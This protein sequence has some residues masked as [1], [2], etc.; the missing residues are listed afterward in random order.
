MET[1]KLKQMNLFIYIPTKEIYESLLIQLVGKQIPQFQI[2]IFRSIK[3]FKNRLIKPRYEFTIA[4]VFAPDRQDI[5]DVLSLEHFLRDIQI[6]LV[7]S[8][9]NHGTLS[10]AHFLR[11]RFI[12]YFSFFSKEINTGEIISVLQEMVKHHISRG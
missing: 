12:S 9:D 8:H 11:P 4:V 5:S 1:I 3:N 10:M 6:I 7:I 2:E